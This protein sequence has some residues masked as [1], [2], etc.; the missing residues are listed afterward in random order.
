MRKA[1][2]ATFLLILSSFSNAY[3]VTY[4]LYGKS[5]TFRFIDGSTQSASNPIYR[6][7]GSLLFNGDTLAI[8]SLTIDQDLLIP[9]PGV[10]GFLE[11]G[12]TWTFMTEGMGIHSG[13]PAGGDWPLSR[14]SDTSY[15]LLDEGPRPN[16]ALPDYFAMSLNFEGTPFETAFIGGSFSYNNIAVDTPY[17]RLGTLSG[18]IDSIIRLPYTPVP[19]PASLSLL[20]A[21]LL[22]LA[23]MRKRMAR[24]TNR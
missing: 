11:G 15:G 10:P 5:E 13:Y 19:E 7:D 14:L 20:A 6:T 18:K 3:P 22:G 1:A 21:G 16:M 4:L 23:A 17:G 12:V 8:G 24:S 9:A 2:I